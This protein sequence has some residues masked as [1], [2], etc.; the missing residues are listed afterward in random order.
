MNHA[1]TGLSS[2]A[3]NAALTVVDNKVT[4]VDARVTAT[5][6]NVTTLTGRVSTVEG[7]LVTKASVSAVNALTTRVGTVE[8]GLESASN[9]ITTL[10]STIADKANASALTALDTKVDSVDGKVTTQASQITTLTSESTANKNALQVQ[11]QVIDGV[12]VNYMV[13]ME[14]NGVVG[15]FG[16]MQS[17]GTLGQVV[18]TFGVNANSFYIGAPSAGKKPFVVTT[19]GQ[20]IDGITYPAGTYINTALIANATIGTAKIENAAITNAKIASLDA[21]K[22]T[23]GTLDAARIRVGAGTTYDAGYDPSVYGWKI[24]T[25]ATDLNTMKTTGK[26]LLKG[27]RTN[28]PFNAWTYLIVDA[29]DSTRVIQTVYADSNVSVAYQRTFRDAAW[30]AWV[31]TNVTPEFNNV[32]TLVEGQTLIEG[33]KIRTNSITANQISVSSLSAISANMGKFVGGNAGQD[34]VEIDNNGIRVYDAAGNLRGV[35]GKLI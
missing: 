35:F 12:K 26:W 2:K 14:T 33:G 32:T 4:A 17:T 34:R 8:G 16:L 18:T 6:S 9:S 5:N 29:V 22:I 25:D 3:S 28:A 21:S 27:T 15:G 10:E 11:G 31:K 7:D 20:Q 30:D 19:S 1:T 24:K 23:T 13:K